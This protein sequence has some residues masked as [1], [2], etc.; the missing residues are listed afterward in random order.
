MRWLSLDAGVETLYKEFV[1]LTQALRAM[2]DPAADGL[3]KK[4]DNVQFIGMLYIFKEVLPQF[5]TL[6]KTFQTDCLNFSIVGPSIEKTMRNLKSLVSNDTP[7][8]K[9]LADM[10]ERLLVC[11]I[12]LTQNQK[13]VVHNLT[14]SYVSALERNIR[15]R[16]PEDVKT[17]LESFDIL[18]ADMVPKWCQCRI[19]DL[20]KCRNLYPSE[21]FQTCERMAGI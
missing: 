19:C 4:I 14:K 8:N 16:F 2:K 9:L 17:V 18:N 12:Q 20:R 21:Y 5:S 10:E 15:E 7:L 6:S 13:E 11:D 1:G 3:L